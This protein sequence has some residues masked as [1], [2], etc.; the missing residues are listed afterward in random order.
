MRVEI[1][2]AARFKWLKLPG[3]LK[4]LRSVDKTLWAFRSADPP[5]ELFLV[6]ERLDVAAPTVLLTARAVDDTSFLREWGQTYYL[7]LSFPA[8]GCWRLR[9]RDGLPDDFIVVRVFEPVTSEVPLW[10]GAQD[11][12]SASYSA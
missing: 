12:C 6:R 7:Q 2:H 3:C 10:V 9:L 8:S 11:S 1:G 4:K 5:P